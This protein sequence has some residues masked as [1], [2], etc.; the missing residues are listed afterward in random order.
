VVGGSVVVVGST[1]V[2]VEGATVV[3]VDG[4]TVVVVEGT[5]V[6]VDGATVVVG[7]KV[8]VV[9][10]STVVM[11]VGGAVVEVVGST[12]V[13]VD[14]TA[15]VVVD[16]TAVVVVG[17]KRHAKAIFWLHIASFS[18]P[19]LILMHFSLLL[20]LFGSFLYQKSFFPSASKSGKLP[21]KT[22]TEVNAALVVH[23]KLA[24]VAPSSR[25]LPPVHSSL[26]PILSTT[27][28]YSNA[29]ST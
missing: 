6:V 27:H 29:L 2:V 16:G 5:A 25:R 3:V 7:S 23:E 8:V 17:W 11:V 21:A 14:G 19:F 24:S 22:G 28:L 9:V 15:V 4:A 12:V 18:C 1:V 26:E 13:V 20:K 10:G